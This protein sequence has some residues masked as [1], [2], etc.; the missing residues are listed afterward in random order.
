MTFYPQVS[1]QASE[2]K[3]ITRLHQYEQLISEP[4]RVTKD[5]RTLTDHW[6]TTNPYKIISKG[7]AKIIEC[8]D[9]KQFNKQKF[10]CDLQNYLCDFDLDPN[11]SWQIWKNKFF[12]IWIKKTMCPCKK[13]EGRH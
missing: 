13:T 12:R 8:R 9:Y 3:F 2:L 10:L 4:K 6:Y 11:I 7:N 1:P 5:T